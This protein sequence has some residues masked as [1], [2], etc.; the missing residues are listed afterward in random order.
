MRPPGYQSNFFENLAN[1]GPRT[2]KLGDSVKS[3]RRQQPGKNI[4][5]YLDNLN[6]L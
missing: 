3:T 1:M 4:E 5:E 2:L 6:L